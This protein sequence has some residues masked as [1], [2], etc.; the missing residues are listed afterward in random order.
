MHPRPAEGVEPRGR[1]QSTF[2][3]DAT[4]DV[5]AAVQCTEVGQDG[6]GRTVTFF[7]FEVY[8]G[9]ASWCVR[10]R[11][12][13][14]NA[15]WLKLCEA[16]GRQNVPILPP[17]QLVK[18]E[19][20]EFLEKRSHLLAHFLYELLEDRAVCSSPEV[21]AFLECEAGA[22]LAAS[23]AGIATC[24]AILLGELHAEEGQR[25][26]LEDELAA[27]VS[28]ARAAKAEACRAKLE[29]RA[30][31]AR[32]EAARRQ[33]LAL[34][35]RKRGERLQRNALRMWRAGAGGWEAGLAPGPTPAR[36]AAEGRREGAAVAAPGGVVP[37][38]GSSLDEAL[39]GDGFERSGRSSGR[40][41]G[42]SSFVA[43]PSV[44]E[45]TGEEL[46]MAGSLLKQGASRGPLGS[47]NYKR[48]HFELVSVAAT[49]LAPVGTCLVYYD[50]LSKAALKGII[51]LDGASLSREREADGR[52]VIRLTTPARRLS[53]LTGRGAAKPLAAEASMNL[54]ERVQTWGKQA[55]RNALAE[56][57]L[58]AP[59]NTWRL[60]ADTA[61]ELDAWAEALQ[62]F[63]VA[64]PP[65]VLTDR[66]IHGAA[67]NALPSPNTPM[68]DEEAC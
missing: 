34:L 43:R 56:G 20:E 54:V 60:G 51:P 61:V 12:S 16:Y 19:S 45:A 13:D 11:Y 46:V 30:E 39:G 65:A 47:R 26:A 68:S 67:A 49:G 55:Y 1:E 40:E 28:A 53:W 7:V 24:A 5:G 35:W 14:F 59:V 9:A 57:P 2:A 25:S 33:V 10:R 15:L 41:S 23:N 36:P 32:A 31:A 42:R 63:A 50:D 27:A 66:G 17:K 58:H 21:C 44:A 8:K 3:S 52:D 6:H 4:A 37:Y 48:R 29:I 18:N 62:R 64:T 38:R 22:H